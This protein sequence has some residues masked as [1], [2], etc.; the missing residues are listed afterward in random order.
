MTPAPF[1]TRIRQLAASGLGW[2]DICVKLH[3]KGSEREAIR[4]LVVINHMVTA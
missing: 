4:S 1:L 2:E 3:A